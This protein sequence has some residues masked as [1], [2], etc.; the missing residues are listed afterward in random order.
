MGSTAPLGAAARCRKRVQLIY[1]WRV[2]P[3]V[4]C[5]RQ[6]AHFVFYYQWVMANYGGILP[7]IHKAGMP[8]NWDIFLQ[9]FAH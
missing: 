1:H 2:S 5:F 3:Q 7:S 9:A 4:R 8:G 6:E